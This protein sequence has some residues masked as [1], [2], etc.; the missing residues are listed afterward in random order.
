MRLDLT[1]ELA[2]VLL[3]SG[4]DLGAKAH[5]L[6]VKTAFNDLFKTFKC[7]A[8]DEED[9]VRV[10]LNELLMRMLAPALRRNGSDSRFD[11]L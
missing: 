2:V 7:A 3:A 4:S 9:V 5:A 11:Y 10:D 8:A 1:Q 6:A